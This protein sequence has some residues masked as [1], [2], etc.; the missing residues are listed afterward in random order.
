MRNCI[1][2]HRPTDKLSVD[3]N[4]DGDD[5]EEEAKKRKRPQGNEGIYNANVIN[6]TE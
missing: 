3:D 4:H 6:R 2:L 1:L 5:D